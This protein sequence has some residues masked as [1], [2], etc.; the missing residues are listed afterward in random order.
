M[1]TM[2]IASAAAI[3]GGVLALCLPALP[4]Q[5][6]A[7]RTFV[8]AAI[9][10]DSNDC[11]RPTPCRTFQGAHDKT[12]PDG[13]VT[14]LDAGGYGSLTI[15]KSISIVNEGAGEA[16]VLVSGGSIG[17]SVNASSAAGYVNLRGIT[18]QGIGFGG[19]SGL[20]LN[21]AYALTITNC[22][23][24][25]HTGNGISIFTSTDSNVAVSNTLVADNGQDGIM[26]APGGS[27]HVQATLSRIEAY[28]NSGNGV[29]VD[30]AFSAGTIDVTVA[31]SVAGGNGKVGFFS[32]ASANQ[33]VA[34]MTVVRSVASNNGTGVAATG[35]H[36][37]L[38]LGASTLSGNAQSWTKV[39]AVLS[40]YGDNNIDGNHDGNL[41]P[42][43]IVKK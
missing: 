22:V 33:S 34:S 18:V 19:G 9:G 43:L 26:I 4:A 5:A 10:N 32:V 3:L 14:V 12:H 28:R 1:F 31:D 25:N 23:F 21:S 39:S 36:A 8:S 13:E 15:T 20:R 2:R 42:P 38:R 30:G 16:S 7:S 27:P 29:V 17:I 35:A 41:A 11:S 40:S 24:R 6:Q 37:E